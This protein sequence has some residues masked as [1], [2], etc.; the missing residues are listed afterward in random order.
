MATI[1]TQKPL[2]GEVDNGTFPVGQEVIFTVQ[3]LS[4]IQTY[5]NV[6]YLAEL[7]VSNTNINL[8]TNTDL[9][10]TFKTTPNNAGVGIFD[11][12]NILEGYV[13]SDNTGMPVN[14]S[15][16]ASEYKGVDYTLQTPHPIHVIDKYC[17]NGNSVKYMAIQFSVV[18]STS[19]TAP[20]LPIDNSTENSDQYTFFNGVLQ[21][22]NY[23]TLTGSN[24]GYDLLEARLYLSYN[25]S[26]AGFVNNTKFLSN[27]PETQYADVD[28][29]GVF[30]FTQFM[31]G[32]SHNVTKIEV[33]YFDSAASSLGTETLTQD[34]T[35]GGAA[36]I[37]DTSD[38]RLL[39]VGIFPAN[40][41]NWSSTFQALVTAGT[42]QGG[43]YTFRA[44]TTGVI[45]RTY[46]INVNCPDGKGYEPIRLA[47]LN[48][49][50][51]WDYY[52]FRKKSVKAVS[53]NRTTYTQM[54]GTWND[55]TYKI[56]GY[57]GGRKNF[58][59]NATERITVN[60]D[61]VTEAEAAWFEELVNST[62]VYIIN[63]FDSGELANT[64]T[65]KY[66]EPVLITTSDYTRKTIANDK[67]MQYT[68]QLERN[69]PFRT[70]TA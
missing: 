7:H 64:I 47:W 15:Y 62:E 49:W 22:D 25:N 67:L 30:S 21:H 19:P 42:I 11:F 40:L 4:V 43:Y 6:Q 63:K 54:N 51:T 52:T 41:R 16:A 50:G 39:Y 8:S 12:S 58:R 55:S 18:G 48:Q 14:G 17:R 37:G 68:F 33:E 13:S 36:T 69:K 44:Y 66:V 31:P 61:F 59:V 28:D 70:Q 26:S 23:L 57:K 53:T 10:A 5:W 56:D 2:Y 38:T 24:Y 32:A 60:S 20:I 9:V 1:I 27:M 65:N 46:R 45:S 3:N 35:T 34:N 29:Y